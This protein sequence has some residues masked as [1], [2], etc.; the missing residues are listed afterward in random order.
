[1]VAAY[2]GLLWGTLAP[3][4]AQVRGEASVWAGPTAGGTLPE[5]VAASLARAQLP[6]ES[7]SVWVQ[8]AGAASPLL[9]WRPDAPM[10]P[11]SLMKLFT[12]FAALEL[13]GPA[14]VWNTPVWVQGELSASG[15]LKG[16][17]HI[18]GLGDPKLVQERV[19]LLL[20]RLQQAG[21]QDIQGDIVLDRSAFEADESDPGAFDGEPLRPYNVRADALLLNYKS[22]TLVFTPDPQRGRARVSIEPALADLSWPPSVPLSPKP[23]E[24]WRAGLQ[25]QLSDTQQLRLGGSYPLACGERSWPLAFADTRGFNAR[26]LKATWQEMGGRLRG[27]VREGPAPE[28]PPTFSLSS[29]PLAEVVRDINKF[30]N[31][32]MAQQLFLTLALQQRGH[33]SPEMARE[34]LQGWG[35]Q[36]LGTAAQGLRVDNGSGLSREHR[37]SAQM[38][39]TLLQKAWSSPVMPEF[40]SSLPVSGV[41]GTL[42]R[43]AAAPGLAHLKTGS[44]RDVWG[45]AGYLLDAKGRRVV[46]VGLIN[47]PQ[48][49][50][51]REAMDALLRWASERP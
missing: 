4:F 26:M 7:L 15:V 39:G 32:V 2:L 46:V 42:K 28:G 45:L 41:D 44:L 19:W 43:F 3:A 8:E 31:N 6:P 38:L 40:M 24:D 10:N 30:S 27:Q 48:A 51:G 20:R 5:T 29:Q 17:V 9:Q 12:T 37:V 47:H 11:A 33:G 50:R 22:V 16:Q 34:V 49:S 25:A 35:L 23:C 1:M 13:L 36:R 21:V 18:Q 14:W